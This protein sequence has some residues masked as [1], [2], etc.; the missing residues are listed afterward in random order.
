MI[1][2]LFYFLFNPI[3]INPTTQSI[4]IRTLSSFFTQCI[5][6]NPTAFTNEEREF[7]H[8]FSFALSV[9]KGYFK[10]FKQITELHLFYT[11]INELVQ[12]YLK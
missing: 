1:D 8:F 12:T 7:L 4:V 5:R 2:T 11:K 6:A 3:K 9:L 10:N